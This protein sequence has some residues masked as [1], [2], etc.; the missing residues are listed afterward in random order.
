MEPPFRPATDQQNFEAIHD[1]EENIL[2]P[3]NTF[4]DSSSYGQNDHPQQQ[5]MID[6]LL[7]RTSE[8]PLVEGMAPDK[9]E[10]LLRQLE[11]RFRS[12]DYMVYETYQGFDDPQR[13]TVGP[14]PD[15]VKPAFQGA[16]QDLLPIKHVSLQHETQE[17]NH[18][19]TSETQL[20]S[21]SPLRMSWHTADSHAT[22][23]TTNSKRGSNASELVPKM[24][25][26][27]A[28][29][30]NR[31]SR[32]SS[33]QSFLER[34]ERDRRRSSARLTGDVIATTE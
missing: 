12:F 15:W 26:P 7:P 32:R 9:Y 25:S 31:A 17:G 5:G 21:P 24:E 3:Q 19:G 28:V 33:A 1:L 20:S 8:T 11:E 29:E 27:A 18:H 13:L 10:R 16:D 4:H 34:R 14:P 22:H 30:D 23:T 6:W 2:G